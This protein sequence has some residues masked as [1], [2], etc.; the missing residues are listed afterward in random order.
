[1]SYG[2]LFIVFQMATLLYQ[3]LMKIVYLWSHL[4]NCFSIEQRQRNYN[5][6][7]QSG[8]QPVSVNSVCN[9]SSLYCLWLLLHQETDEWQ[10]QKLHGLQS[11]Q[12]VT[13]WPLPTLDIEE[14]E[15][16]EDGKRRKQRYS[17]HKQYFLVINCAEEKYSLGEKN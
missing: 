4:L 11:L 10:Q 3:T 7:S 14:D 16:E 2:Y 12:D 13:F 9:H 1:M 15:K 6:W 8:P 5:L 17:E